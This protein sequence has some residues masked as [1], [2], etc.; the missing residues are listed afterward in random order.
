MVDMWE[1]DLHQIL[2]GLVTC[3]H[4][5]L[6]NIAMGRGV[7]AMKKKHCNIVI[8]SLKYYVGTHNYTRKILSVIVWNIFIDN[9]FEKNKNK[10]KNKQRICYIAI[11]VAVNK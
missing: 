11:H 4:V 1:I 6:V 5:F 7:G 2:I 8:R 3:T 10:K 9:P